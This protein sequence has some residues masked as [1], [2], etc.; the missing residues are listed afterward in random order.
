MSMSYSLSESVN[1][2]TVLWAIGG[3]LA[4]L[5]G[6]VHSLVALVMWTLPGVL[7]AAKV[8]GCMVVIGCA[9]AVVVTWPLLVVG[10]FVLVCVA[11]VGCPR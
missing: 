11:F 1:L 7:V 9:V 8:A 2:Q 6:M 10:A 4:R 5:P 3:A